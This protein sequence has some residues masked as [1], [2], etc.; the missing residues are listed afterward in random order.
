VPSEWGVSCAPLDGS[1]R[2]AF[3]DPPAPQRYSGRSGAGL[4]ATRVADV[5]L[6]VIEALIERQ[7]PIALAPGVL[8]ATLQDVLDNARLA[9]FD[10]WLSLSRQARSI[11]DEQISDYIS[12]LTAR[13]PLVPAETESGTEGHP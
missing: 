10:D 4:I 11:A 9:Y 5:K 1:L 2:L 13:G 8:A 6:R 3:P 12:A 7:L